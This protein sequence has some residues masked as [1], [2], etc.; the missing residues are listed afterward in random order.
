MKNHLLLICFAIPLAPA[1]AQA[2]QFTPMC[3]LTLT[4]SAPPAPPNTQWDSM[5]YKGRGE[6]RLESVL[7]FDG[8]PSDLASLMPD[9]SK[10]SLNQSI[11]TWRLKAS[12]QKRGVWIACTYTNTNAIL[13]M[14]LPAQLRQCRMTQNL[15]SKGQLPEMKSFSCD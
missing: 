10:D 6:S 9:Q 7:L 12:D 5:I 8:H 11:A 4:E 1:L 14:Q 15:R 13:A 3:P 2:Q